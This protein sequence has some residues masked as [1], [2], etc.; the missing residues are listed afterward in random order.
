MPSTVIV[1]STAV[2]RGD[3]RSRPRTAQSRS[4]V[5]GRK[6]V[7]SIITVSTVT[8]IRPL[9]TCSEMDQLSAA[10]AR[11]TRWGR[12]TCSSGK[13]GGPKA[14]AGKEPLAKGGPA[15]PLHFDEAQAREC[16]VCTK[17]CEQLHRGNHGRR[18]KEV[19][20][21]LVHDEHGPRAAGVGDDGQHYSDGR[22][23]FF[24]GMLMPGCVVWRW[25]GHVH[26]LRLGHL[27][28]SLTATLA[29]GRTSLVSLSFSCSK[30]VTC[31]R[32]HRQ[33]GR[34]RQ[35]TARPGRQQLTRSPWHRRGLV[36]RTAR[37][38]Q[39]VRHSHRRLFAD[40][41][42]LGPRS[43][44]ASAVQHRAAPCRAGNGGQQPALLA[45][46]DLAARLGY[47]GESPARSDVATKMTDEGS[48]V[49]II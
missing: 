41:Q 44:S 3:G 10:T 39:G 33:P 36:P 15:Q 46:D 5:S 9:P 32:R 23:G 45:A 38:P 8:F 7:R 24:R 4:A 13:H 43:G 22:V 27:G 47:A 28:S 30:S 19:K 34:S 48:L 6:S 31:T 2:L 42:R 35:T 25:L 11:P 26:L 16:A 12:G 18:W 17:G 21:D 40:G 37:L 14:E 1:A 49:I 20:T 29:G